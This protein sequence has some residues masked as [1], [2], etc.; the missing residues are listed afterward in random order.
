M[1]PLGSLVRLRT[2]VYAAT[3]P[4]G[5]VLLVA[6]PH[7]ESVGTATPALRTALRQL[8][9]GPC[10]PAEVT[11]VGEPGLVE[12]LDQ[13]GWLVKTTTWHKRPQW[14]VRPLGPAA[15]GGEATGEDPP[16][17][18]SRFAV[19]HREGT[20]LVLESPLAQARIHIHDPAVLP[21]LGGASGALPEA[22]ADRFLAELSRWGFLASATDG[23]DPPATHRWSAHEL[24]FHTRTRAGRHFPAAERTAGSQ[25]KVRAPAR[26]PPSGG[27]VVRLPRADLDR[28]RT[29]DPS[30]TAVLEDRRTIREHDDSRPLSV[31]VI[32]EF[33]DRCAGVRETL[34]VNGTELSRRPYPAGGALYELDLY[35]AVRLADGLEPGLYRHDPY[36]HH[37]E[38]VPGSTPA[39]RRMLTFATTAAEMSGPPQLLV[40]VAARFARLLD[41]YR[42]FGYALALK[43]VG[44]LTQVMYSVA[45]AMGLAPCALGLG[46]TDA[47]AAA[48]GV[49]PLEESN[50]GELVLGS[51]PAG[52]RR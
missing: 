33:L 50:L 4:D 20:D 24:W 12:R 38:R 3:A 21:V 26:R 48:A 37:L 27:P 45:T 18:L 11:D 35:V 19:L 16:R 7:R 9:D 51:R 8:A 30:L 43:H 39:V 41:K 40:V 29:S 44:V 15:H 49:D 2:G 52:E 36:G 10:P 23:D 22:L 46:D 1:T 25:G 34:R 14:T 32:G 17:P 28:L 13:T 31:P 5:T 42:T 6:P 47:F